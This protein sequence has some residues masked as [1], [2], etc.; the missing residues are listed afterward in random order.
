MRRSR[1]LLPASHRIPA[2][3][4]QSGCAQAR[5]PHGTRGFWT[6]WGA[7]RGGL[8]RA[9]ARSPVVRRGQRTSHESCRTE[10]IPRVRRL[11]PPF[12]A[13][14][15]PTGREASG[16]SPRRKE[17]QTP[18]GLIR[19]GESFRSAEPLA[20]A[21][22]GT[23]F[24]RQGSAQPPAVRD[25]RALSH[26]QRLFLSSRYGRARRQGRELS[27]SLRSAAGQASGVLAEGSVR[28]RPF[29]AGPVCSRASWC[30]AIPVARRALPL[31][32]P[33]APAGAPFR[34]WRKAP[35][36]PAPAR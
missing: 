16:R 31:V 32:A 33:S 17:T 8:E 20:A 19:A 29:P 24:S 12:R 9:F 35:P 3:P 14:A 28:E 21:C 10:K 36:A 1:S 34:A 27:A 23:E 6:G 22:I 18:A 2:L 30:A 5:A 25:G 13:L 15:P 4:A 7:I 11:P 26:L